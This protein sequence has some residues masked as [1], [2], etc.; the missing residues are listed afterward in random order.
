MATTHGNT[1]AVYSGANAVAEV[2]A[3]SYS[4][5]EDWADDTALGD[6][7]RSR[8]ASGIRDGS[9]SVTCHWDASDTTGQETLVPGD[10]VTLH[11]YPEGNST[12][13]TEYTGTAYIESV[14]RS[15]DMS[16]I[17]SAT[18]SFTGVMAKATV[19]P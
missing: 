11:L 3:W 15:G 8:V 13:N 18:F 19:G 12:S 16:S 17:V 6:T 2:T 10:S 9:G 1:G 5:T 14:E 7:T 4:E